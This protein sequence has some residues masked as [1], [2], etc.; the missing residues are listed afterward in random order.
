MCISL[1][2]KSIR[3][4]HISEIEPRPNSK[5][6]SR[7]VTTFWTFLHCLFQSFAGI[8]DTAHKAHA[9]REEHGVESAKCLELA[10]KHSLAVDAPKTGIWPDTKGC[11]ASSYPDFMMVPNKPTYISHKVLGRLFREVRDFEEIMNH[12]VPNSTVQLDGRL[13]FPGYEQYIRAAAFTYAEYASQLQTLLTLYGIKTEGEMLSS[14]FHKLKGDFGRERSQIAVVVRKL[15]RQ[16]R[17]EF[18]MSF[19]REFQMNGDR[20]LPR[21]VRAKKFTVYSI[22]K[23]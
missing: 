22:S 14:C 12:V 23:N 10:E 17:T 3:T 8:I 19:F 5:G 4:L 9:D 15:I 11:S 16:L 1:W 7:H 13:I 2:R 18:R 20:L 21:Q 6:K